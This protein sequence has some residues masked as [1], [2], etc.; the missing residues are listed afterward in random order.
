MI[1]FLEKMFTENKI[2]TLKITGSM[3][4]DKREKIINSF[5]QSNDSMILLLSL[6]ATATG[7]NLTMA[8]NVFI[9]DP[10]WNV[11]L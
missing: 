11:L 8:N 4:T 10:W 9:V 6:R 7:L 2:S 3:T 5:K 1:G